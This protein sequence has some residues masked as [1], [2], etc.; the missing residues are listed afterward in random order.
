MGAKFTL[1]MPLLVHH[2]H[3]EPVGHVIG[4]NATKEGIAIKARL[5]RVTEPGALKDR[6]DTV[7]QEIKAGLVRGLSIGFRSTEFEPIADTGGLRFLK[8]EIYELSLVTIPANASASISVIK[9][10][11]GEL[12]AAT[13]QSK[14]A[15]PTRPG[16]AAR[17]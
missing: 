7:W 6:L 10:I 3:D 13:G 12:A 17:P 5:A 16:A 4:A 8:S 15:V 1:P 11:D 2:R 9:S 14:R